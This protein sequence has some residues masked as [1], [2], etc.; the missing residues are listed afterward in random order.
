GSGYQML[1]DADATAFGTIIP[2]TRPLT[3]SG[4]ASAE[5]YAE[6]EYK[7]PTDADG[8][9][10]T[11]NILVEG[12]LSME[13]PAGTYDWCITNPTP[14]D[15]IWIASSNGNVS[16]RQ[17]D[18]VFEPGM[19]YE[20]TIHVSGTNDAVDLTITDNNEWTLV[21]GVNNPY[22][23]E[24]LSA[25]TT[26]KYKVQ[27]VDCDGN[28][29]NTDWSASATFT[30]GEFYTKHI[31]AYEGDGGYYLIASPVGQVSPANVGSM[32]DN[33]YDL[34]YFDQAQDLEWI[35][36]KDQ[37]DGGY[38]LVPGKGY[39]YANSEDVDLVFAG[40]AYAESGE[41][42]LD[43][44]SGVD[45]E[46]MN[47]VGNPFA[48]DAYIADNRDFYR[49]AEG[50]AEVMTEASAGAIQPMEGVFVYATS[51]GESMTFTTE[52][53]STKAARLTLDLAQ[54]RGNVI[55][56]AVV[57][58]GEGRMLPKFQLNPSHTKLYISQDNKDY[59]VVNASEMGEL[60]VS[61]KAEKNGTYTLSFNNE[62]VEFGYLHL[63]DN[64]T[65]NDVD[66]L[67]NPS[68]SFEAKTTDYASRFKLVFSTENASSDHFAYFTDGTLVINN[69][70]NATMNVYD[71]TGRLVD[72]QSVNGS[73]QVGFNAVPGVYMIQ[74]V[75]GNDVKTQK[76]VVK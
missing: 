56:R 19:T 45:F 58:F 63:I 33:E 2:E 62:N 59:A 73:C 9:C 40:S 27:G 75:N 30:T 6:F 29:N 18:Y 52:K 15:R 55:D 51:N 74:L 48:V 64:M 36:Y 53:P 69:E 11:S 42:T 35:N 14:G 8:S 34:Y 20:F 10:S 60:P 57:S 46:G 22:T 68:Y 3:E 26:Y 17:D 1:I 16:G 38:D 24:N 25:Q 47:L 50:G 71:V 76:I 72:T 31:E 12:S 21:E 7:L 44:A 4:D 13:I 39:L 43:L 28:G 54:G 41:V 70:G 23:L 65:G 32:L 66:L 49:L 5:T 67:A 37:T 61:F